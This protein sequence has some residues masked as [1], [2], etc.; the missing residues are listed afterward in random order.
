MPSFSQ[1]DNCKDGVGDAVKV[2]PFHEREG[3]KLVATW[4][5]ECFCYHRTFLEPD[6]Y[7]PGMF[8]AIACHRCGWQSVNHGPTGACVRCNSRAVR[9]LA[10]KPH[11]STILQEATLAK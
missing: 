2:V 5:P 3:E 6:K 8:I 9:V 1:C 7:P 10:P 4:C 11:A